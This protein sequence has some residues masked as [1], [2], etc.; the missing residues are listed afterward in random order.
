MKIR[1]IGNG[2]SNLQKGFLRVSEILNFG[3]FL[4]WWVAKDII[5]CGNPGFG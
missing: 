1:D 4:S 3:K 5:K 2:L